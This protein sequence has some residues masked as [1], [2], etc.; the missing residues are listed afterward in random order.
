M[1][2][3]KKIKLRVDLLNGHTSSNFS[4]IQGSNRKWDQL[5][6]N[7]NKKLTLLGNFSLEEIL[8]LSFFLAGRMEKVVPGERL[9][10]AGSIGI[11]QDEGNSPPPQ[12]QL[13]L[14]LS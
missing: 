4:E 5:E 7:F 8:R 12:L 3:L 2:T 6:I 11:R 13:D 10:R 14:Y 1:E 9:Q